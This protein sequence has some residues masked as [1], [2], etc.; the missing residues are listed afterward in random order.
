MYCNVKCFGY[1]MYLKLWYSIYN[2]YCRL[3]KVTFT[4]CTV[5]CI[6]FRIQYMTCVYLDMFYITSC[7]GSAH[8][9]CYE[10][11]CN[12]K[13]GRQK[14]SSPPPPPQCTGL[15]NMQRK[16]AMYDCNAWLQ[17]M[18]A[19]ISCSV[20]LHHNSVVHNCNVDL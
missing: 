2:M 9:Y 6:I 15:A 7:I 11:G 14:I 5:Y 13:S 3:Y 16:A 12:N 20:K 18:T 19:M 1:S 17:C 4:I 8:V 10:R